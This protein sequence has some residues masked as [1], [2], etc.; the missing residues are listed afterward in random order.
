[1]PLWKSKTPF[2]VKTDFL[3]GQARRFRL[4]TDLLSVQ[5]AR[6]HLESDE[7]SAQAGR[8]AAPSD[9][10]SEQPLQSSRRN[11]CQPLVNPVFLS[12]L[13]EEWPTMG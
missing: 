9:W 7:L 1:M 6:G 5:E 11:K 8:V 3:S 12:G 2:D 4:K 10:M 13:G